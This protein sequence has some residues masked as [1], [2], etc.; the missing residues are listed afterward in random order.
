MGGV[1]G[2]GA[3]M[4]LRLIVCG[5]RDWADYGAVNRA[6]TMIHDKRGIAEI[7]QGGAKGADAL[8]ARWAKATGVACTEVPADWDKH[9]RAAGPIRNLQMLELKPDG[10]V[11]FPGGRGT[12]HMR[13]AATAA[14]VRVWQPCGTQE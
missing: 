2:S 13:E 3:G 4:S 14:G 9:G 6:L 7:I 11:A 10:V 8:A 12:K 5:G 1:G